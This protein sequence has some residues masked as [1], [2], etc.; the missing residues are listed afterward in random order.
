MESNGSDYNPMEEVESDDSGTSNIARDERHD[1]E[2]RSDTPQEETDDNDKSSQE[3]FV[4]AVDI[5]R[6]D[7]QS[8]LRVGPRETFGPAF[9]LLSPGQ[10]VGIE[11]EGGGFQGSD[12][13][14]P[15]G[16]RLQALDYHR[17]G[18][19]QMGGNLVPD[20]SPS[21]PTFIIC[22]CAVLAAL[23]LSSADGV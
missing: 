8:L 5:Q 22:Y 4:T 19:T 16:G 12:Y 13:Q 2:R 3:D 7:E 21:F 1:N 15:G 10:A 18:V 14:P 9:A 17:P 6:A 20:I 11:R 23:I